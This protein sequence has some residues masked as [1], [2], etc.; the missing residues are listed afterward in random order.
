[1]THDEP[2]VSHDAPPELEIS[3]SSAGSTVVLAIKGELDSARAPRLAAAIN[4][5][6]DARPE[7]LLVDL[8]EVNFLDTTALSVLLS[9]RRRTNNRGIAMRL[10]CDDP[11]TLR[12]L[13][14]TRVR[15]DFELYPTRD[16]ALHT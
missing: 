6:L 8:C 15:G 2:S 14:L 5:A 7:R 9:A 12:L 13:D 16:E 4:E 11:T 3:R 10:A 1:M